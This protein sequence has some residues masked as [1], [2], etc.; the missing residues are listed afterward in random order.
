MG[1]HCVTD[2]FINYRNYRIPQEYRMEQNAK[3]KMP[4]LR[5]EKEI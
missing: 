5:R 1:L 2:S 3:G 4:E